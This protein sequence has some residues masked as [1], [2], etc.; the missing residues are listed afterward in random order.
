MS[1][2]VIKPHIEP[3]IIEIKDNM[4]PED[5]TEKIMFA[6]KD[7]AFWYLVD[8]FYGFDEN[9]VIGFKKERYKTIQDVI[10]ELEGCN[11]VS[12]YIEEIED[13]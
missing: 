1:R 3:I 4:T 7:D 6:L 8:R 5:M 12:V 2:V 11:F 10:K 13:E 9:E